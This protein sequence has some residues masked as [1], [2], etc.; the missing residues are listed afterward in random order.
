MIKKVLFIFCFLFTTP[1]Y[2]SESINIPNWIDI[3]Y[4]NLETEKVSEYQ[5]VTVTVSESDPWWKKEQ[6]KQIQ[7]RYNEDQ[8]QLVN[9]IIY[10]DLQNTYV[11]DEQNISVDKNNVRVS[12]QFYLKPNVDVST[13]EITITKLENGYIKNVVDIPLQT[14]S[15]TTPRNIS[16]GNIN[17]SYKLISYKADNEIIKYKIQFNILECPQDESLKLSLQKNNMNIANDDVYTSNVQSE[18]AKINKIDKNNYQL[19]VNPQDEF[20]LEVDS[21]VEGLSA[22]DDR[23]EFFIYLENN[24]N[25]ERIEQTFFPSELISENENMRIKRYFIIK[26]LIMIFFVLITLIFIRTNNSKI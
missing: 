22:K 1:L 4:A 12:Y 14:E 6:S 13:S 25:F 26:V 10:D 17:L 21:T 5:L 11:S 8:L 3:E 2:A 19:V 7:I 15:V 20:I 9:T 18:R 23:F 16:V 24:E